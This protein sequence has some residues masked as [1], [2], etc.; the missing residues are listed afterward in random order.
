M[1]LLGLIL[2]FAGIYAVMAWPVARRPRELGIR[3]AV[4]ADRVTVVGMFLRQG[5]RLSVSGVVV[6]PALSLAFG[7]ALTAGKGPVA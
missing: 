5:L 7:R 1:G 2:A 6:G 4:G 3:M